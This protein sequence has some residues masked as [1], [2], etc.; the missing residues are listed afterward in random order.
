MTPPDQQL[1]E[2]P[3]P[4]YVSAVDPRLMSFS[5]NAFPKQLFSEIP[6]SV[7]LRPLCILGFPGEI[8]ANSNL[9]GSDPFPLV[10]FGDQDVVRCDSCRTY[11]NPY[12]QFFDAGRKWK[13]NIC[14]CNN[15]VK[16]RY[17]CALDAQ[18]LRTDVMSRAELCHAAVDI[19]APESYT[20]RQPMPPCFVT[21]HSLCVLFGH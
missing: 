5:V 1:P 16:E 3:I 14:N 18:G 6:L 13:C 4:S 10:N 21:S 12:V 2:A 17:R 15:E 9:A 20:N 7:N 19:A 11:I 8:P